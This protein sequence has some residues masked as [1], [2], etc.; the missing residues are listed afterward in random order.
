M[1]GKHYFC[2]FA[3]DTDPGQLWFTLVTALQVCFTSMPCS[4]FVSRCSGSVCWTRPV[5]RSPDA[6]IAM[7][8]YRGSGG[9]YMAT[10]DDIGKL[11]FKKDLRAGA[12]AGW[13]QTDP[14][15]MPARHRGAIAAGLNTLL[16]L[17]R[18]KL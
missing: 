16:P 15:H 18:L 12:A 9:Q 11:S 14:A 17:S 4:C 6:Q 5:A 1:V 7:G 3:V 8:N 13:P 2:C 10:Q